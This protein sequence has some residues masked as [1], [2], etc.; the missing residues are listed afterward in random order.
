MSNENQQLILEL[1]A[2]YDDAGLKAF[3]KGLSEANEEISKVKVGTKAYEEAGVKI[4][5]FS[6]KILESREAIN[7]FMQR[8]EMT[9][10][11]LLE[12]GENITT[13]AN[14]IKEA[15]GKIGELGKKL[16]EM[17]EAGAELRN[18]RHA[19]D[20]M[21]GGAVEGAKNF[22]LLKKASSGTLNDR[23]ILEYSN[24]LN[25][26]NYSTKEQTTLLD[27]AH[28]K[29]ER[30][31]ITIESAAMKLTQFIETGRG[32]G[33]YKIGIDIGDVTKEMTRLSGL[34]EKQIKEQDVDIQQQIRKEAVLKLYGRTLDEINNKEYTTADRLHQVSVAFDNAKLKIGEFISVGIS[35]LADNMGLTSEKMAMVITISGLVIGA[36]LAITA[37]VVGLTIA[38][39]A[40]NAVSGGILIILGA[41]VTALG[42][43]AGSSI[44]DG[45]RGSFEGHKEV[46]GKTEGEISNLNNQLSDLNTLQQ[47]SAET[48][49]RTKDEQE[50]YNQ[51]LDELSKKYPGITDGININRQALEDE[52]NAIKENIARKEELVRLSLEEAVTKSVDTF[53]KEGD[54]LEKNKKKL[55]DYKNQ[56]EI[57]LR[58]GWKETADMVVGLDEQIIKLS[59]EIAITEQPIQRLRI[60]FRD[61]IAE[62]IKTGHVSS[63]M[64]K[65]GTLTKHNA[66]L[67]GALKD[68]VKGLSASFIAEYLGI[69]NALEKSVGL[70]N[71]FTM[72][73]QLQ[74]FGLYDQASAMFAKIMEFSKAI[75]Q[76][77]TK[78]EHK[79]KDTKKE[80]EDKSDPIGDLINAKKEKLEQDRYEHNLT[81][82]Q[83]HT[84]EDELMTAKN[85][86]DN[87]K[88]RNR[89]WSIILDV[90]KR[91]WDKMK[92]DAKDYAD[93]LQ[94]IDDLN[95]KRKNDQGGGIG[96]E[97][98]QIK[99][100]E[101]TDP[102]GGFIK[103]QLTGLRLLD[104]A[105]IATTNS[106]GQLFEAFTS[107]GD[108]ANDAFKKFLKSIVNAFI[109]SVQAML[110]AAGSAAAAKGITS[111]GIS[112][113]T[114]LPQIA[115][116]WVGLEMAKGIIAGLATGGSFDS[117]MY[118]VG[119]RGP[120][121]A[122]MGSSGYMINNEK[123]NALLSPNKSSSKLERFSQTS[124]ASSKVTNQP[125]YIMANMDGLKFFKTNKPV[126]DRYSNIKRI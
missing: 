93:E 51:K 47:L 5:Y 88:D 52:T 97:G 86:A 20:E 121:L 92:I 95:G 45:M 33:L 112:L 7:G 56:K 64:E 101:Q 58:T 12:L 62:G 70:Q 27:L 123:L 110:F 87:D 63:V 66:T 99:K 85:L 16:F 76:E 61:F 26:L 65:L 103:N 67:Q 83:L 84:M 28:E 75:T 80:N 32:K 109:S 69:N 118:L 126:F 113:I 59:R 57:A 107:G 89:L 31:G 10:F 29:H 9:S 78:P 122:V 79:V 104:S 111:F 125:V 120:E 13:L 34:T 11:K 91:Y 54:E 108:S 14:G 53:I 49:F 41:I 81:L 18:M 2:K 44:I 4:N 46:I 50:K 116:A 36:I 105:T 98:R 73:M 117:G 68:A 90:Q 37:A 23:Q 114:D 48:T 74:K 42:V 43:V 102:N 100:Y 30:L 40:L 77:T 1:K 39:G 15:F 19:F 94:R 38:F 3:K 72:A 96:I 55:E 22:E 24:K 124:L 6:G 119:E 82:E 8:S 17:A 106:L 25:D 21:N 115:L 71:M 60:N 35:K